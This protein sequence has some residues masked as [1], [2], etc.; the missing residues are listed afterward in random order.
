MSFKSFLAKPYAGYIVRDIH[1]WTNDAL[2]A[3]EFLFHKL[4]LKAR[5]TKFGEDH[6][7]K[8]INTHE[9]Y[10]KQVPLR[11]YEQIASY[12][13]LIK[14]GE[15]NILWPGKPI[16]FAKSSGTT[17]GVKYIPITKDS[18]SNHIDSARN[19]L[20]LYI[21]NKGNSHFV[22]GNM[23][24]LSGSPVMDKTGGILTGRLSGI[25]N[26]HVPSYLRGNQLPSYNTNCIEDW[27][28]K[29]DAI[30][31]E[32]YKRNMTLISGI[33]PWVQMYFD[34]LLRKT[35]KQTIKDVFPNLQLLVYGGVNFQ[36]YKKH[37]FDTIGEEIDSI[38]TYPASEGFIAYQDRIQN[39]GL[40]LNVDSGIFFE[41][42]HVSEI[43]STN[44][45]RLTLRDVELDKQYAIILSNTAGLWSYIL[46]DTVK[47]VSLKPFRIIVT[48]RINHFI[49]AFGEHVISEEVDSALTKTCEEF[50]VNVVE[51]TV[52]PKVQVAEGLPHHEWYI[53]FE[54]SPLD[55]EAFRLTLD[56][57]LQERNIYYADLIQGK[58]LQPLKIVLLRSDSF[59]KYMKAKGKLGAQNKVPRLTNDRVIADELVRLN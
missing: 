23:I 2:R 33:P 56:K 53:E 45:T 44:P 21:A 36:P 24:F 26:H 17:S 46:G 4:L 22:N 6:G 25:V 12:I 41:F 32:T 14:K 31:E 43:Q 19:A 59:I 38:E 49:S 27:E 57:H 7:F 47:F 29:L 10:V 1:K 30:V 18:I 13:D 8:D 35:G 28:T 11:D 34:H 54:K 16:Y 40:L 15:Q 37:L 55:L 5:K 48:G 20:L 3:Q 58:I 42:V 50:K 51:Y 9:Q 39:E 52:A